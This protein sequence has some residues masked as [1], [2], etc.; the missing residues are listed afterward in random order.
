MGI[1][2]EL[3]AGVPPSSAEAFNAPVAVT[4]TPPPTDPVWDGSVISQQLN[5]SG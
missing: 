1:L 4:S 3:S 2:W 5:P